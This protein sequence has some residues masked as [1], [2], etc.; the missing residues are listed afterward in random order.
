MKTIVFILCLFAIVGDSQSQPWQVLN[1]STSNSITDVE[2]INSNLGFISSNQGVIK[3]TTDGGISWNTVLSQTIH[4]SSIFFLNDNIG[5]GAGGFGRIFKTTNA[6]LNWAVST[7]TGYDLTS[8]FFT[9]EFIGYAV[10][11]QSCIIKTTNG[12][13]TWI[14]Q[15]SPLNNATLT[16][17]YF[18]N[19]RGYISVASGFTNL[20]YTTNGGETWQDG[21]TRSGFVIGVSVFFNNNFGYLAGYEQMEFTDNPLLFKTNDNGQTWS[22]YHLNTSGK[23]YSISISPVDPS[24]ACA[25]GNY[26]NDPVYGNQGLIM[27]TS[28][29]GQTWSE[30]QWPGEIKLNAVHASSTDFFIAGDNGLLL[31]SSITVGISSVNSE[32]PSGYSLSQN[33]PNPFNPT[34]NINFSIPKSGVVKLAIFNLV[35]QE[36]AVILNQNLNVGNYTYSFDASNL[37]T[38]IYFYTLE[39]ENFRET[40]RM[41]LLK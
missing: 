16:G 6:G 28:D 40:K 17:V 26:I 11:A 18:A 2:F 39:S 23:I 12:G 35:G 19:N 31:K 14:N 24:K 7:P 32:I 3:R 9:N 25:V 34:T 1:P 21:K 22:E 8:I 29:G 36:V 38:G 27:R 41:V 37:T 10:G 13:V 15:I 30:E 5:F 33:Y 4:I 20:I